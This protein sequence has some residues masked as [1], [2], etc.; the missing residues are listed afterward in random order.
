MSAYLGST[1]PRVLNWFLS[2]FRFWKAI[3][4]LI[5]LGIPQIFPAQV[6]SLIVGV[7]AILAD[8]RPLGLT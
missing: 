2:S 7:V 6:V 8:S 4:G 5:F 3:F 1:F